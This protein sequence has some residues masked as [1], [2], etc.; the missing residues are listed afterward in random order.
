VKGLTSVRAGPL[1]RQALTDLF[2]PPFATL[3]V[4]NLF[5]YVVPGTTP[6]AD[7]LDLLL[8]LLVAAAS[9][10]VQIAC[11]LAAAASDPGRSGDAWLRAAFRRRCFW[12]VVGVQLLTLLL[13]AAGAVLLVVGAFVV[14]GIISLGEAAVVLE[15]AGP[16]EAVR[17]SAR[18]TRPARG[19][20]II[21][22]GLLVIA[23]SVVGPSVSALGASRV[24]LVAVGLPLV[25]VSMGGTL[26]LARAFVALGGAPTPSPDKLRAPG[27][28]AGGNSR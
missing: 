10:Y 5:L 22:F 26:A 17:R 25:V 9:V 27:V 2:R 16:I 4:V 7:L 20:L 13:V 28:A 3:L 15:R 14:G 24:A 19:A 21:V 18:L 1:V 8:A 23:P 6:Q 12:R 11:I